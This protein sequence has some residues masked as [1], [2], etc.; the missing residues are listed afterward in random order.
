ADALGGLADLLHRRQREAV[1]VGVRIRLHDDDALQAELL[2]QRLV[3]RHVEMPRHEGARR[4]RQL[5][6]VEMHVRVAGALGRFHFL[7]PFL[8]G[9]AGLGTSST[10]QKIPPWY[11]SA[12]GLPPGVSLRSTSSAQAS[13]S[14][15]GW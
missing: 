4:D 5:L 2:L 11:F 13:E 6:V 14:S 12:I 8:S 9:A 15:C 1:V 7:F 10:A 3:L